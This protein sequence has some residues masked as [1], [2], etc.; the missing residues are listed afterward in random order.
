MT[1]INIEDWKIR[2]LISLST[3]TVDQF[4]NL[5]IEERGVGLPPNKLESAKE[6]PNADP[7]AIREEE[8]LAEVANGVGHA[9]LLG[10]VT[11]GRG[12]EVVVAV[13]VGMGSGTS[14]AALELLDGIAETLLRLAKAAL[15]VGIVGDRRRW[16]GGIRRGGWCHGN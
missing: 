13:L 3:L 16:R 4:T 9:G 11:A 15:G 7:D 8:G 1:L 14:L 10:T 6:D 12:V 5:E 2:T